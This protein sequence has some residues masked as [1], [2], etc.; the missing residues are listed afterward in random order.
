MCIDFMTVH[1]TSI[2]PENIISRNKG[3]DNPSNL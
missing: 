1:N 3:E 2:G